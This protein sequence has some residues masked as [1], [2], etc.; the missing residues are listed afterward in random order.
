MLIYCG[1]SHAHPWPDKPKID[2]TTTEKYKSTRYSNLLSITYESSTSDQ[3]KAKPERRIY[4]SS[5]GFREPK[6]CPSCNDQPWIPVVKF[7]QR[8][9]KNIIYQEDQYLDGRNTNYY[10]G[11]QTHLKPP[12]TY[13]NVQHQHGSQQ[14][15]DSVLN[16][17]AL[18]QSYDIQTHVTPP[19]IYGSVQNHLTP[20]Q[21]YY[22]H[23]QQPQQSHSAQAVST[24]YHVEPEIKPHLTPCDLLKH[25]HDS[26]GS[27]S[28]AIHSFDNDE[29][30]MNHLN[31]YI[32]QPSKTEKF[33]RYFSYVK[34]PDMTPKQN[35]W[36]N[37][38]NPIRN[39]LYHDHTTPNA[40]IRQTIQPFNPKRGKDLFPVHGYNKHIGHYEQSNM[41]DTGY[42]ITTD[43]EYVVI[44]Y[45]L[46]LLDGENSFR[47]N[48]AYMPTPVLKN[49]RPVNAN[50]NK[51]VHV[52]VKPFTRN[53][54]QDIPAQFLTPPK[55][56]SANR[57]GRG[58]QHY[59]DPDNSIVPG[60]FIAPTS[61]VGPGSSVGPS[62]LESNNHNIIEHE[63]HISEQN[64]NVQ[65]IIPPA[66]RAAQLQALSNTQ[67]D[68]NQLQ[69]DQQHLK[70]LSP[71]EW[72][73]FLMNFIRYLKMSKAG[74][75][76]RMSH[77]CDP[78][79]L[80]KFIASLNT[81]D[82]SAELQTNDDIV[83]N[84]I[85]ND[86]GEYTKKSLHE[87]NKN[88]KQNVQDQHELVKLAPHLSGEYFVNTEY[89]KNYSQIAQE[90]VNNFIRQN[91][92]I[93]HTNDPIPVNLSS[94]YDQNQKVKKDL[95][96]EYHN[97]IKSGENDSS[98]Y[99]VQ[100]NSINNLDYFNHNVDKGHKSNINYSS[101]NGSFYKSEPNKNNEHY[102]NYQE[103]INNNNIFQDMLDAFTD[104]PS[105][106][107]DGIGT[108]PY[109]TKT[110][111]QK[112]EPSSTTITSKNNE[113]SPPKELFYPK[114][115]S[116]TK[117]DQSEF[118]TEKPILLTTPKKIK[119]V[120]PY[121][122]RTNSELR[123]E[124]EGEW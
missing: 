105:D 44:S 89:V 30:L 121:R 108:I 49:S 73:C 120:I 95:Q 124:N 45:P 13:G 53:L 12:H 58:Y 42:D 82:H 119:I 41:I 24:S 2:P 22:N 25:N 66:D 57:D 40:P 4:D 91:E 85:E 86:D 67:L 114:G 75:A 43:H 116:L 117:Y 109:E 78:I 111:T 102:L 68:H 76:V 47:N 87:S 8:A 104:T 55:I 36:T 96:F 81:D 88:M 94:S 80:Q 112:A 3:D 62:R 54:D 93:G 69:F 59:I 103:I 33:F 65:D 32:E 15:Y 101:F 79:T 61:Y 56:V 37:F 20:P 52:T 1:L 39:N 92:N 10:D 122:K 26:I 97:H 17:Q 29:P 83:T 74:Y 50:I 23:N 64:N 100:V 84:E 70:N 107:Y 98:L 63:Q 6:S 28:E 7:S 21:T 38:T 51:Q 60:N 16:H 110:S 71:I 27:G 46:S 72:Q 48:I 77:E 113:I 14:S 11:V 18:P 106:G 123:K 31:S 5:S 90:A 118:V 115:F 35:L 9:P 19:Q 34:H 99:D